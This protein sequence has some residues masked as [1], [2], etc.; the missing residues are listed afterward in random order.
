MPSM[1]G[2]LYLNKEREYTDTCNCRTAWGSQDSLETT[3]RAG[4]V[5]SPPGSR[6]Q[7][8]LALGPLTQLTSELWGSGGGTETT[9]WIT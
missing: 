9:G 6:S 4:A 8:P 1:A 5:T 3:E 7:L 2:E